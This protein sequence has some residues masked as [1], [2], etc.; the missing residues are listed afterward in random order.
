MRFYRETGNK[1]AL[2]IAK[3]FDASST[4]DAVLAGVSLHGKRV[5]VTG[6]SAGIGIETGRPRGASWPS[7][8]RACGLPHEVYELMDLY[9][10]SGEGPPSV[11]YLPQ[12]T[13]SGTQTLPEHGPSLESI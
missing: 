5:L 8:T 13:T 3:V 1:Q 11:I 2:N 7:T 4:T 6:V 9:P 10:Q 12:A